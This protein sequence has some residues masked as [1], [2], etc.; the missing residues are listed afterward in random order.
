MPYKRSAC[1]ISALPGEKFACTVSVIPERFCR[2]S[3]EP[4]TSWIPVKNMREDIPRGIKQ[5]L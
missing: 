4:K 1:L 3:S 5:D 2:V